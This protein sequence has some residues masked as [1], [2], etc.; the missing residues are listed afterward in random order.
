MT[1]NAAGARVH[2]EVRRPGIPAPGRGAAAPVRGRRDGSM[3][4]GVSLTGAGAV[5]L[6]LVAGALGALIDTLL[7]PGLGTA[8]TIMLAVGALAASWLVRR[9]NRS[10]VV[11]APPLVYLLLAAA[12]LLLT[13]GVG[14][15]PAALAA[16]LVYGFPAMAIATGISVAVTAGRQLAGR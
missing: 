10:S 2:P 9:T 16:S 13:S 6:L 5:L 8:T 3:A 12:T 11:I 4:P 7:G 1:R 14:L 15:T